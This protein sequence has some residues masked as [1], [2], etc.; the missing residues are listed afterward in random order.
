LKNKPAA[1]RILFVNPRAGAARQSC[2]P[3]VILAQAPFVILAKT[4][5][6]IRAQ[7]LFVIPAQAGI[8]RGSIPSRRP[9]DS[10]LRGMTVKAGAPGEYGAAA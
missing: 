5:F 2:A 7:T 6:V 1:P 8:Q 9:L 10:R 4:P 3:F